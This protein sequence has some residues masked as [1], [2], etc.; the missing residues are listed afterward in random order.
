MIKSTRAEVDAVVFDVGGVLIEVDYAPQHAAISR[1]VTLPPAE[2]ARRLISHP[3]LIEF[4]CGRVSVEVFQREVE[5]VLGCAISQ[6]TFHSAW[7]GIFKSEIHEN[8][9]ILKTLRGRSGFK[10]GV[11]SNTNLPH[12]EYLKKHMKVLGEVEHL[13]AS[14]EI[15]CRKPEPESYRHVLKRMNVAPE[16]TVFIDDLQE[17]LEG[18]RRVGMKTIHASTPGAVKSGLSEL[19]VL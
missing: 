7:N 13:Y 2:I 19:G 14:H 5:G 8:V 18:A 6:E 9:Q 16:R 15:G 4:E 12:F 17:N 3:V 1:L 10:V 11:L